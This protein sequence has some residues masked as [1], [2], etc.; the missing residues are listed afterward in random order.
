M[1]ELRPNTQTEPQPHSCPA[2]HAALSEWGTDAEKHTRA[3]RI[4]RTL[5]GRAVYLAGGGPGWADTCLLVSTEMGLHL[6][7]ACREHPQ[8]GEGGQDAES[9]KAT[10][11]DHVILH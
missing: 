11:Q 8:R 2:R 9:K 7:P 10:A 5:V 4:C 3:Q 1:K 6:V